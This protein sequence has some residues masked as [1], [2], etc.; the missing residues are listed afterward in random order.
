LDLVDMERE[1]PLPDKL[2]GRDDVLTELDRAFDRAAE[3]AHETWLVTGPA[4]IGKSMLVQ[5]LRGRAVDA[6]GRF[7]SGKFD[8][9]RGNE[10]YAPFA[11][12][13]RDWVRLILAEPEVAIARWRDRVLRAVEPNGALLIDVVP[14]LEELIGP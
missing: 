7:L 6:Q 5:Q 11:C 4:G 3:G 10:P 8:V 14:E 9:R 1:L 12:A 13:F 2:Y